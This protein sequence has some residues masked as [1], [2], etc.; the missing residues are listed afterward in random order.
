MTKN[1]SN[2]KRN[3][4]SWRKSE[5]IWKLYICRGKELFKKNFKIDHRDC[6]MH[7][8]YKSSAIRSF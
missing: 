6:K 1:S 3:Y 2:M 4:K 7:L 8:V 5:E